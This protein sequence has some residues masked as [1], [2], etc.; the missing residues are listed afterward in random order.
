MHDEHVGEMGKRKVHMEI[1]DIGNQ[2]GDRRQLL[3]VISAEAVQ[4]RT[5]IR[6]LVD[7][8]CTLNT[9]TPKPSSPA[10]LTLICL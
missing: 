5:C 3:H 1:K 6:V 2:V 10:K 8:S 9:P 7:G 4:T